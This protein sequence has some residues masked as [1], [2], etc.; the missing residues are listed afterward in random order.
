M[1]DGWSRQQSARFLQFA[2]ISGRA[3]MIRRFGEFSDQYPWQWTPVEG[4]EFIAHLRSGAS[5]IAV[6]T[7]RGYEICISLFT[8]YLR[9]SRYGWLEVCRGR[10]GAVPQE[11]FHEGNSVVH[12][13]DYEGE[14]SRRPLTYDEVQ[15][16]F[17]AADAR[18][19]QI[20]SRGRKGA[21]AAVRD[22]AILKTVYAYGLRRTET[23]L[24]D[25]VD[26]RRNAKMPQLGRF[27]SLMVRFGKSSKGTAPKRRT[28]LLVPE[29]D[30][31]CDV[32]EHWITEVRPQFAP[33][34]HPALWM[35]ERAG[36]IKPRSINEAF[37]AAREAA[38]LDPALDLHCLRH[39]FATHLAEFG[40]P[41]RFVQEQMGHSHASTTAIYT[42]MSNEFRNQL[43]EAA[44]RRQ[45][46]ADWEAGA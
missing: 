3:R 36:R 40:Y 5:P 1:V 6:S 14:P 28:V 26:L 25:L 31:L 33:G 21:L 22:A 10:F 20:R 15:A 39:S 8:E 46:G 23:S 43:M 29:M 17:D 38:G 35:T 19:S 4:E 45:L 7:A 30:W 2:T 41:A 13:L 9:D 16:L 42:S 12:K 32:L 27:G 37:A 44:M 11:V 24:L 34:R 18:P